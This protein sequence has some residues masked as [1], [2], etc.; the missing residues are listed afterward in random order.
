MGKEFKENFVVRG[1]FREN[2]GG[3]GREWQPI[4]V[5]SLKDSFHC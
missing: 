2:E 1:E 3:Y 5:A 4:P